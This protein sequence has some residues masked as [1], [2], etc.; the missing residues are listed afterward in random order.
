MWEELLQLDHDLFT[1]INSSWLGQF[2]RF[3]VL[4]TSIENWI[5]LYVLFFYLLYKKFAKPFNFLLMS[6]IP[7]IAMGTLILTNLVKN[8][9]QRL[10]PNNNPLLI[11]T[12]K[13]LQ[14]PRNFSFWS[15]H[16]A[17]SMAVTLF[18]Y[19]LLNKQHPKK[20]YLL[21]FIWPLL[22]ALSRIM[23]GVH[24]PSDVFVGAIV[25]SS[26]GYC[27]YKLA[28]AFKPKFTSHDSK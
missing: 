19:I 11:E 25:G 13:I 21:F 28:V 9:I 26:I 17:V 4:V 12:I 16:T 2:D 8:H 27:S 20:W 22:F 15:G 1:Y 3:W 23:N 7:V 10:R 6:G 14:E 18:V 24:F 5:P